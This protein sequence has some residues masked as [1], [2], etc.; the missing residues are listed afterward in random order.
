MFVKLLS[1]VL[2]LAGLFIL[3][4]CANSKP[5]DG[6]HLGEPAAVISPSPSVEA[7]ATP[8]PSP[9][10]AVALGVDYDNSYSESLETQPT[11]VPVRDAVVEV[12]SPRWWV[13]AYPS[14]WGNTE[15]G[16]LYFGVTLENTLDTPVSVGVSFT[17]YEADGT[18]AS[19]CYA[20]GGDGPGV[21]VNIAPRERAV[22]VCN[23]SIV[24]VTTTGLKI[25]SRLWE[26]T[27]L[28]MPPADYEVAEAS[29]KVDQ[30][31][32]T[33]IAYTPSALVRATGGQDTTGSLVF[34]LYNADNVQIGTCSTDEIHLEPEVA[35]RVSCLLGLRIG[36]DAVS[37]QPASIRAE[38]EPMRL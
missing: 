15:Q 32:G 14:G 34:R 33:E 3:S 20:P 8:A 28:A 9:I 36:V 7:T 11:A 5:D 25:T 13:V 21:T 24:P 1:G 2:V 26:V 29:F 38:P 17:S 18:R 37:Q 19:G 27:A 31:Y 10:P 16:K 35:Q 6:A 4:G 22:A 23:R 12:E 30:D